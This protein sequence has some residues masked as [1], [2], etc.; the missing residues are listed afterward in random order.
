MEE[1]LGDLPGGIGTLRCPT[2]LALGHL[3]RIK[4]QGNNA[5]TA[6][7]PATM[8]RERSIGTLLIA[9]SQRAAVLRTTFFGQ[10]LAGRQGLSPPRPDIS[11]D[12]KK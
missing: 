9:I 10:E 4:W 3:G 6:N 12:Y 8:T 7:T 2:G 1:I 5:T 11:K